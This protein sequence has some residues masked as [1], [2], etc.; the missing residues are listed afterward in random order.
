MRPRRS[1]DRTMVFETIDRGSIPLEATTAKK[2]PTKL[3]S[4]TIP[5]PAL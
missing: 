1:T 5:A 2:I 3:H 4:L